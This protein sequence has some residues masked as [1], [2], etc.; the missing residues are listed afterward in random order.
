M[1]RFIAII[2]A[3]AVLVGLVLLVFVES[4]SPEN[5]SATTPR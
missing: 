2:V 5:A 3:A 1:K 4:P